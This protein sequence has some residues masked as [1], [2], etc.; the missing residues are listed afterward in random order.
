Y[1][2]GASCVPAGASW[3]SSSSARAM[4]RSAS[5]TRRPDAVMT[6]QRSIAFPYAEQFASVAPALPGAGLPWLRQAREHGIE[7][8]AKL[9]LP[10]PRTEAWKY[11]NLNPLLKPGFR[12]VTGP[13]GFDA[14][15]LAADTSGDRFVFV[16]G[17]LRPD[18]S[19]TA[20]L[21]DG[22]A[23]LSFEQALRQEPDLV[24]AH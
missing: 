15:A 18:L 9:G 10:T 24:E 20:A 12:L 2:P 1:R 21:P 23:L 3:P 14:G 8:F 11:T 16:N 6:V 13:N 4:L 22:V 17:L 7:R 19:D 5:R